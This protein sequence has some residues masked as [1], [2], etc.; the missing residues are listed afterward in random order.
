MK[1][2]FRN[3]AQKIRIFCGVTQITDP[4]EQSVSISYLPP[5]PIKAIITDLSSAKLIWKIPGITTSK[6]KELLV[7]K[8]YRSLLEQ[9]YKIEIDGTDYEGWK[10]NGKLAIIGWENYIRVYVY[11]KN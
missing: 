1:K 5:V 2:V 11:I 6:V 4:Y 7:E 8:K 3:L 10:E 9:S